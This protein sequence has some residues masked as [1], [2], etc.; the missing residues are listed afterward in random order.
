MGNAAARE[1]FLPSAPRQMC[2][3]L[4]SLFLLSS[5]SCSPGS[6]QCASWGFSRRGS[7]SLARFLH[8]LFPTSFHFLTILFILGEANGG[9]NK[10]LLLAPPPFP[11][12]F[13][14]QQLN[15]KKMKMQKTAP[16]LTFNLPPCLFVLRAS[17]LRFE[18]AAHVERQRVC[19]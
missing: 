8:F 11:S 15:S 19:Y 13:T 1:F 10:Q 5:F 17:F 4:L 12:L 6:P 7:S 9:W 3:S 16:N 18:R 2:L 14:Q